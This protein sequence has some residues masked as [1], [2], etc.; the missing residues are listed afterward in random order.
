[1]ARGLRAGII[2]PDGK[3]NHKRP[4]LA[5]G[6]GRKSLRLPDRHPADAGIDNGAAANLSRERG[7]FGNAVTDDYDR[8]PRLRERGAD[9]EFPDFR[10]VVKL[11]GGHFAE[12]GSNPLQLGK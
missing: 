7:H 10:V 11:V 6:A 8:L 9:Y 3:R 2:R 1:M 4:A 5:D 12:P